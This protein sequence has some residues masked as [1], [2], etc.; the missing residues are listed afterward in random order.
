MLFAGLTHAPDGSGTKLAALIT[1]HCGPLPA[2]EKAMQPLK[3]FGSPVMDALGPMPYCELNRMLDAGYPK[4]AL[5]YWK[6][7]FLAQLSDDAIDTMI[8]CFAECPS[9]MDSIVLEH[10][11][12]RGSQ[13]WGW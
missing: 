6:S 5:N 9:P 11:A 13:D 2:G 7:S 8:A 4:G 12:R 1:A 3:K 10:H